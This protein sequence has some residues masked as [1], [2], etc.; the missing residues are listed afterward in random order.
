ML[1]WM[2][3]L[4]CNDLT[5]PEGTNE[6]QLA[7]D[8][9]WSDD[10]PEA[11]SSCS[12]SEGQ[13]GET[14]Q[15]L[16]VDGDTLAVDLSYSGGC[17]AHLFQICW[18]GAVFGYTEPPSAILEIWHGGEEDLCD[19]EITET[20]FFDLGPLKQTWQDESGQPAGS[21]LI[22]LDTESALYTF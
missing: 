1:F 13:G 18:P 4:A 16:R 8:T 17:E 5:W 6:Q 11:F 22:Q 19:M 20:L 21:L 9:G 12:A 14:V 3:T 7:A 15:A 2:S 10:I